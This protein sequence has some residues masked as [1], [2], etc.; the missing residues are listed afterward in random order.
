MTKEYR[1]SPIVE[2]VCEFRAK[3][4][5]K[6]DITVPGLIY[7]KVKEKFPNREQ[8][9]FQN[10]E[11]TKSQEDLQHQLQTSERILLLS[12]DRKRFIQ[13]GPRLLAVNCLKPYPAWAS[14]KEMINTALEALAATIK[15]DEFQRIGLR[16]INR[17]EIPFT[18]LNLE[19]YFE[20]RPFLGK[21]LPQDMTNFIVGCMLMFHNGRDCCR[22][23][24]TNTVSE[25]SS[26]VA[27]L[28]D[29]DYSLAKP[30]EVVKQQA[31]EWLEAAH[32]KVYDIFEGC[33][34]DKLRNIFEETR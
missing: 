27:F 28:L 7:E 17:I 32:R 4:D 14:F 6:W 26:N 9:L 5:C 11:V 16:Y 10:L 30:Q 33:I 19:E 23:Q 29:L 13:V 15:I 21:K 20:F 1:K 8:R 25:E 24:L 3:K 2:A 18:S 31:M 34:T 22:I 12:E